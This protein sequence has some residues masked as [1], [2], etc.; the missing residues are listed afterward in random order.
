MLQ[1]LGRFWQLTPNNPDLDTRSGLFLFA[2]EAP[3][4][5]LPAIFPLETRRA[6]P[7]ERN[8]VRMI[9]P[10]GAI[11]QIIDCSGTSILPDEYH[12]DS[13]TPAFNIGPECSG[14]ILY[15]AY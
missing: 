1:Y 5:G 10:I 7:P 2:W 15:L 11:K 12:G 3:Y 8:T 6:T 13:D 14:R 9:I 4:M